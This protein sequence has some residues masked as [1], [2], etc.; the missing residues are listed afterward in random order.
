[1]LR[2]LDAIDS[3]DIAATCVLVLADNRDAAGLTLAAERGVETLAV[4]RSDYADRPTWEM[5]LHAALEKKRANLVALAGFMRVLSADFC[6]RWQGAMLNIHPSLLPRHKGL[7]THQRA[8]DAGDT[9]AGC[10]VHFVTAELDEGPVIAQSEVEILSDDS[11]DTLGAR[12]LVREHVIYPLVVGWV[13]SGRITLEP[14]GV[15]FDATKLTEP[16]RV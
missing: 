16:K 15:L 14:G 3:G 4:P 12:V 8:L 2:L 13:A 6:S 7:D 1:M 10:S 5:A 9:H 11:A